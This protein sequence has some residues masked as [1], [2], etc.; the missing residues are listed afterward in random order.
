MLAVHLKGLLLPRSLRRQFILTFLALALFIVAGSLTAIYSLHLST[1]TV[2]HMAEERLERMQDAQA[3]VQRTLLIERESRQLRDIGTLEGVRNSYADII[4]QL[5]LL[6]HLVDRLGTAESDVS[7]LAL[8]QSGQGFRNNVHVLARLLEDTLQA[9]E[10]L[11]R[12]LQERA[13]P[14]LGTADPVAI[15]LAALLHRLRDEV[16]RDQ[17]EALR[18][19]FARRARGANSLPQVVRDDLVV[20]RADSAA[21]IGGVPRDPF[22]QRLRLVEQ[23]QVVRYADGELQRQAEAMMV[24]ARDLSVHFTADYREAF[25]RLADTSR[26]DQRWVLALLAGTLFLAW[27]VFSH[28]LGKRVLARLREVSH[29]LRLGDAGAG[30]PQV[31][32]RG[33]DE[34]AEMARAV[35]QLLEDR[36]RL[37]EANHELEAFS[38]SVSHDLRAPL[39]HVHG[40]VEL[41]RQRI[42]GSL[43]EQGLHYMDAISGAATRMGALVDGLL[44]F[45]LMRRAELVRTTVDVGALVKELVAELGSATASRTIDWK[46]GELPPVEADLPMLR[47]VLGHLISNAVKFTQPRPRAEIEIGS[48]RPPDRAEVVFFVRDNGVGFDMKYADKLFR[49]FQRLHR[50]D[51]FAGTGI[52][53]ASVRHIVERHGGRA[54]A[55]GAPWQGATFFFSIPERRAQ[56]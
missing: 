5:E 41:L 54:W 38:Y 39:R 14:L 6:D 15:E 51:D 32:V 24:S 44:S 27:L 19:Q 29:Y 37:A 17:I 35:E 47:M 30:R 31:P 34:I 40:F 8:H 13:A 11:T 45:L 20:L 36:Q 10:T 42:A 49:V 28:F 12:S 3:L 7:V 33:D 56:P 52:G 50:P 9:N 22:S 21:S 46:I 26:K 53:L 4:G 48:T 18:D 16:R 43:D 25:V 23:E 1:N 2:R 55:E